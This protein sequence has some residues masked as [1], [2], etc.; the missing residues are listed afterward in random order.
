MEGTRYSFVTDKDFQN[1]IDK[2][3]EFIVNSAA[4]RGKLETILEFYGKDIA[5]GKAER[6]KLE[7]KFY[8]KIEGIYEKLDE[9]NTNINQKLFNIYFK[10]GSLSAGVALLITVITLLV[11]NAI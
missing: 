9:I 10:L 8:L 4:F 2:F 7:E 11:K 3:Q 1:V 6:E 5:E